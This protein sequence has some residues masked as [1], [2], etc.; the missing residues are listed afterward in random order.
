M[1]LTIYLQETFLSMT[2][3][4]NPNAKE[5]I[6]FHTLNPCAKEFIPFTTYNISQ[7]LHQLDT[8]STTVAE[9]VLTPSPS[10]SV[11]IHNHWNHIT[12]IDFPLLNQL[13]KV[14]TILYLTKNITIHLYWHH[15]SNRIIVDIPIRDFSWEL[16]NRTIRN[17]IHLIFIEDVQIIN[18]HPAIDMLVSHAPILQIHVKAIQ[19]ISR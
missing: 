5:F 7:Q 17:L 10:S 15:D 9:S 1:F 12:K 19:Y 13:R 3:T 18:E 6:P 16:S 4:L 14:A 2:S 8:L 11:I